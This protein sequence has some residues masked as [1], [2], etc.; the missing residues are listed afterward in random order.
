MSIVDVRRL[1]FG[2]MLYCNALNKCLWLILF[3]VAALGSQPLASEPGLSPQAKPLVVT[4]IKPLTL[5]AN[6]IAGDLIEIRQLLPDG[7]IPH[8][9]AIRLSQHR[10]ITNADLL[11]WVGEGMEAPLAATIERARNSDTITASGL[12]GI[13][14]PAMSIAD[15][16]IWLNPENGLVIARALVTALGE[17][18][19]VYANRLTGNLAIF[20]ERVQDLETELDTLF[21]QSTINCI[22]EHDA[23][24]HFAAN[25][26]SL[27]IL[28]SL[29]DQSGILVGPRE[30]AR[31]YGHK[32]VDC[33]V[34]ETPRPSAQVINLASKLGVNVVTVDPLGASGESRVY[35]DLIR[36]VAA[37]FSA[38]NSSE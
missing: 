37:G 25:F 18:Y 27:R 30:L 14:T 24:R 22:A 7:E 17:K 29:Y 12:A 8:H 38:C 4:S 35:T 1:V 11:L 19:P 13:S 3:G 23:Y 28:G 21:A 31:V 16:H 15:Q 32:Q 5:I 20:A 36:E 2:D 10:L 26:P 33:L 34:S 6:E 9:F